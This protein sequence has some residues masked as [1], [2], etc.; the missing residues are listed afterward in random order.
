MND[1]FRILDSIIQYENSK[2]NPRMV[3]EFGVKTLND[4][5]NYKEISGLRHGFERL[6]VIPVKEWYGYIDELDKRTD[7]IPA[8]KLASYDFA[9]VIVTYERTLVRLDEDCGLLL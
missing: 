5:M 1:E 4:L 9:R 3:K 7:E 6:D 2:L 8:K